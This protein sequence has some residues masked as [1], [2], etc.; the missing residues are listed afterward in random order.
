[1]NV[2]IWGTGGLAKHYMK[3][4][5]FSGCNIIGFIDSYVSEASFWGHPIYKPDEISRLDYDYL[6]ICVAKENDVIIKTC[7]KE[8][9]DLNKIVVL[10]AKKD[11]KETEVEWTERIL[12][13]DDIKDLFPLLYKVRAKEKAQR[14]YYTNVVGEKMEDYAII[15]NF[16]Q[17]HLVAWIPIELLFSERTE[18]NYL[19]VYTEEWIAQ[20]KRWEN[21]P[22]IAFSPYRSLYLFF[23][24]G[25][26]YPTLY[27]KWYQKLFTSRGEDSGC[28][29]EQLIEQ[30]FYEFRVMQQALNKG[31]D[32]FIENPASAKW[33]PKGYFN[34]IDGHHRTSFLYC[35]G[36]S[37]IPVQITRKDYEL[38]CNTEK[39][40]IVHDFILEQARDEFYQPILNPFFL[41]LHAYREEVVKSRLHHLLEAFNG[42]RFQGK[43]VL[44]I[45]ANLGFMGQAFYRM[46]ADVTMLEPDSNHC[47]LLKRLNNLLYTQCEV[48][49]EKFEEYDSEKRFD[50]AIL[51]TVF[52]HYFL[53]EALRDK[54]CQNLDKHVLQMVIWESGNC[55]EEEKEHIRRHTKFRNYR[56][57]GYTFATGKF[58]ELGF[59][60][61]DGSEYLE[62][63]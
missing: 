52:Y 4:Q 61:A 2:L 7:L 22:M 43:K 21:I 24:Q 56:H 17:A 5:I 41:N 14:E 48:V 3:F 25:Q 11:L 13:L 45:G 50:I 16:G 26:N 29:D 34:L 54:F 20:N 46:G 60:I 38:W 37:R 6:I 12:Y 15:Q 9:I 49:T 27:C 53:D 32:F 18:D 39:A 19:D 40:N 44:D 31:M 28:T 63:M 57:L 36:L 62:E 1:M 8:N 58:R 59:F 42:R 35:S 10:K 47:E 33:N 51:L 23:L 30:R 55:P